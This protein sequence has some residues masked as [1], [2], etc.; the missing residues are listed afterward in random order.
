M[1]TAAIIGISHYARH[2]LLMALEQM[3]QGRLRLVAA[4]VV[5]QEE[6]AFFCQRLRGLGCE[7]FADPAAMWEKFT[8]RVDLCFIPT[9][10]HLH[11]AMTLQALQCGANVLVEK[12]L[13]ASLVQTEA[14]RQLERRTGRFVAV[15]FQDLYTDSTWD[16]KK[17]LLEGGIGQLRH[18]SL[19][20][21][22]PRPAAYY[23][24]NAWAGRLS[25]DGQPVLDSPINNA[26]AH[27]LNLALFWAGPAE[28][29][30]ARVERVE[31]ELYRSQ[32]IES[33]DTCCARVAL[34][35]G[36]QLRFYVTHSCHEERVPRLRLE[37]SLGSL[38][39]EQE[40]HYKVLR[41]ARAAEQHPVPGK[42]ETKL[43][44]ADAV[45]ARLEGRPARVCTTAIASEHTRLI[46]TIH[47]TA[48]ITPVGPRYLRRRETTTGKWTEL[49]D[50][51]T[52]SD[53]ADTQKCLWSELGTPWAHPAVTCMPPPEPAEKTG[54]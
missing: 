24:R 29:V 21:L 26:F 6:E 25:R 36:A 47:A 44:M 42:F 50:I 22:W 49:R 16:I 4:T 13:A 1:K 10:L 30:S 11:A 15:G 8:S 53:Q 7:I 43:M 9:G 14:I 19:V 12:P 28:A 32:A 46:E 51:E 39:W 37:G 18:I 38:E 31:C 23:T 45:L 48:P 52:A 35:G 27:F 20:G 33:F 5:N 41:L 2:H 3:L 40:S 54:S 17:L 34:S